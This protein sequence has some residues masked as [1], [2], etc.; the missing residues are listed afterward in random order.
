MIFRPLEHEKSYSL[1]LLFQTDSQQHYFNC[2]FQ[3]GNH[4]KLP[5]KADSF[6]HQL[7]DKDI[8]VMATDGVWDN[9]YSYQVKSCINNELKGADI[10]D[11][12]N[13]A[14]CVSTVAEAKSYD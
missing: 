9:L 1:R 7:Q 8:I 11:V 14:K 10:T 3:A 4:S 13:V 5:T 12:Q 6:E 2:P